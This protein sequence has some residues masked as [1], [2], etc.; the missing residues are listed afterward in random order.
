M[1]GIGGSAS[2]TT[3]SLRPAAPT[4]GPSSSSSNA[5]S[6]GISVTVAGAGAETVYYGFLMLLA[7]LPLLVWVRLTPAR[8]SLRGTA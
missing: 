7:G 5:A 2:A 8:A 1:R 3:M 6:S 4:C